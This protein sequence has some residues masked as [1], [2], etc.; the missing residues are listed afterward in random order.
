MLAK[1]PY[2]LRHVGIS[3]WLASGVDPAECAR[4][5]GQG[6]QV[7]FRYYAKFLVGAHAYANDRIEESMRRW[8]ATAG[9]TEEPSK[10]IWPGSAPEQLVRGGMP[11]GDIGRISGTG[12]R[13]R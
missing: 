8:A 9:P 4:R 3:F 2:D 6:M 5:A 10:R 11:V 12:S 13:R 7:M 1:R